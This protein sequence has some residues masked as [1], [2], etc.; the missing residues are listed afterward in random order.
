[1][2]KTR[3]KKSEIR[4]VALYARVSTP[5]QAE[6]DLSIPA[7]LHAMQKHCQEKGFTVE[8]EYVEP[9]KTGTD[10]NRRVFKRMIEDAL[11]P[12]STV[13]AILVYQTSRFMRNAGKARAFKDT[14]RRE[15]I[16]VM[17]I[18]QEVS[19][20]P[21]GQFIEGIFELVDQYESDVNG[22][23]T[24]AALRENARRGYF[25]G[26]RP[27]YGFK[28]ERTE[29]KPDHW[30]AKLVPNP[31]EKQTLTEVFRLYVG[32]R[33]A[34]GVARDLNQRG[35]R[36]RKGKLWTKDLVLKVVE[37][38]A[39]IGT[40]HWGKRDA[41]T[42]AYNPEDEWVA[43]PVEPVID[44]ELYEMAQKVRTTRNPKRN[45]GRTPSSPLLLAGLVE[46]GKCGSSYQLETSGK[47]AASGVY[48]YRYYQCR[49]AAR[50]GKEAC[51]G[52][53]VPTDLLEKTILEHIAGQ[54]F[55]TERCKEI[56]HDFVE[57]AGILRQ[58]TAIQRRELR[59]E[60]DEVERRVR[61]WEEA[62]ESGKLS[63]ADG[64]ERLRE[65]VARRAELRETLAK[66]VPLRSPPA[67]LY[68]E[69]SIQRFQESVREVFLSGDNAMTKSYLGFLLDK[70]VIDGTNVQVHAKSEAALKMMGAGVE[71]KGTGGLGGPP[72][73]PT[74]VVDWLRNRP[75]SGRIITGCLLDFVE[76][77]KRLRPGKLAR[78]P[79]VRLLAQAEDFKRVLDRGDVD[80]SGL[81][82]LHGMS[83][84]RVTQILNLLKLHPHILDYARDLGEG[85]PVRAVTER[86]L[87][88]LGHLPLD[89]QV[90][91][92]RLQ[93][94][95]FRDHCREV[96]EVAAS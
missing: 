46:C 7:Q 94:P 60:L 90:S 43:I 6:K 54:L 68:T 69:A 34:K 10:E 81:A 40:Y 30:K 41:K 89:E 14:L 1:M 84:A 53:R 38:E 2:R 59:R 28:I 79:I 87:R 55:T 12:S 75:C 66:V 91:A 67:H 35:F 16:R 15:G 31:D 50:V 78:P 71:P 58:K 64:A 49:Q 17:S 27:P 13:D 25:N 76:A 3:R 85:F 80:Q 88:V 22:M 44:R 18:S 63:A 62:F 39:A 24:R 57:E 36:Y 93:L 21:T 33:G 19:D 45:P 20:D 4:R 77:R 83:R 95:G 73:S 11:A 37:E 9:G 23:R 72:V 74:I 26:S 47:H 70:I 61:R 86:K 42:R 8:Q 56:L 82:H 96:I 65:L 92:A 48:Q 51:E 52:F 5:E 32:G 29:I